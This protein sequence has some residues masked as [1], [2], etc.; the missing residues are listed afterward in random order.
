MNTASF[1]ATPRYREIIV[2][3]GSPFPPSPLAAPSAVVVLAGCAPTVDQRGNLPEPEKLAEI[4]PGVTTK[5]QVSQLLGTPSSVSTFNDKTW[6]YISRGPS[7]SSFFS[8]DVLDQQVFIVAFDDGGVVRER[9]AHGLADGRTV[10]PVARRDAVRRAASSALLEQL[11]GNVGRF[12]ARRRQD[13]RSVQAPGEQ[14]SGPTSSAQSV[15]GTPGHRPG[16]IS[17]RRIL[18]P[19]CPLARIASSSSATMLMILIIGLTAG[20]AVSL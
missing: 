8:P 15:R 14:S 2:H 10:E 20:P 7:R 19:Q 16:V 4:K 13:V 12:N 11:I 5:E 17:G 1:R 9:R 3:D 6:Y 18:P